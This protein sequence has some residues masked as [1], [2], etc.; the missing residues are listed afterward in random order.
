MITWYSLIE[1]ACK[2]TGDAITD[3]VCTLTKE[4]LHAD[5]DRVGAFVMGDKEI[6]VGAAPWTA[7]S[8]DW[9]YFPAGYDDRVW[10][11]KAPRHVCDI[12]TELVGGGCVAWI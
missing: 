7:W 11:A 9:V 10:V 1:Q 5:L 3:L 2:E 12:G 4:E 8:N 6:G